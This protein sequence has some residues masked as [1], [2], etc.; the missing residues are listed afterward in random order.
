MVDV[1]LEA[2]FDRVNH[3]V[4]M[5][6]LAKRIEDR[7]VLGPIRRYLNADIMANGVVTDR[8]EGTPPPLARCSRTCFS[9]KSTR[10]W[11][12]AD[13][14]SCVSGRL[15]RLRAVTASERAGHAALRRP[16]REGPS[17]RQQSESAVGTR[18]RAEVCAAVG[19]NLI[20][21]M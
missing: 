16:V 9:T 7:R 3:D 13:T 8:R 10:S 14:P 5:E 11:R 21:H 12:S 2:F 19:D 15:Q 20:A 4:L 17:T 1:D 6:R 18:A